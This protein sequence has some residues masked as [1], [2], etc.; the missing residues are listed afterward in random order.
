MTLKLLSAVSNGTWLIVSGSRL[1]RAVFIVAGV[2]LILRINGCGLQVSSLFRR[3]FHDRYGWKAEDFFDDP[4]T[5]D[6]CKAIMRNDVRRLDRL[7][8]AG[9]DIN[10]RGKGGMTPLMWAFPDRTFDCFR[11]LLERGADPD[12]VLE[13]DLNTRNYFSPGDTVTSIILRASQ[14]EYFQ[15]LARNGFDAGYVNENTGD[16]LLHVTIRSFGLF[17][18][19]KQ[20]ILFLIE[21]GAPLDAVNKDHFTAA[22]IAADRIMYDEVLLLLRAGADVLTPRGD[23]RLH[24]VHLMV[25]RGASFRN[26]QSKAD[27]FA[28]IELLKERGES[29]ETARIELDK[30]WKRK[31]VIEPDS[32]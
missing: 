17:G 4:K 28:V 20:R 8:D 7:I 9:A 21:N 22:M 15:E 25:N 5:R 18:D 13:S 16:S 10:A 19:R 27:Y 3:T 2:L 14:A 23:G 26:M 6:L 11:R 30:I 29:L 12:V 24:L 32:P 31:V 1:A